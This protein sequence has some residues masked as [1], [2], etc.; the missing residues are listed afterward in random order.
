MRVL[1]LFQ[2]FSFSSST[3]YLDLVYALRDAGHEVL[4]TAGITSPSDALG[5]PIGGQTLG[6]NSVSNS[7]DIYL[8]EGIRT[9]YVLLPDQFHAG[10]I[11][12]GLIQLS[13]G[14]KMLSAIKKGFWKEKVDLIIYPTPPITL[15]GILPKLKKHFKAMTFLMLKDIFPQN[16]VDLKMMG[17]RG[18]I[19][20]HFLAME[21]RL[22]AASDQIGCMSQGN[23]Q[24]I[25]KYHRDLAGEKLLLFP[26]TVKIKPLIDNAPGCHRPGGG[27]G[28]VEVKGASRPVTFMFGGNMGR[29]QS[30]EFLLSCIDALADFDEA[31]F[32]FIGDG[33]EIG[34]IQ[35]FIREKNPPNLIY[36]K[37]LPRG[38]Y[39]A[40]LAETDV[41][42]I[43]L[44]PDFTIPN[45]PSRV[46]SYMQLS[47]P[48]LA[49]TDR[50][51]DI[52]ALVTYEARCGWWCPSDDVGAFTETIRKVC[53]ERDKFEEYG[54]NGRQYL[55]EHF[56]VELSVKILENS[57]EQYSKAG[58]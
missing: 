31:R 34:K 50:V 23:I 21:N 36:E 38:E 13:I 25:R 2:K 22:Y 19:H 40:R 46:L 42:L 55:I 17:E 49:V 35:D 5:R 18:F 10:K 28:H 26:N 57:L 51:T 14:R 37:E 11:R 27:E 12:K 6:Q 8:Y 4:L 39:E 33:T 58:E 29:P 1:C 20:R 43:S 7:S 24:Y 30:V 32:L 53:S 47:K 16:A 41:G 45:Y 48:V 3:I 56:N 15:A 54:Q 52:H 44:S 9:V